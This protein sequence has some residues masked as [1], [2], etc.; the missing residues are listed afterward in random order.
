MVLCAITEHILPRKPATTC[1]H[2]YRPLTFTIPASLKISQC[3]HVIISLEPIMHTNLVFSHVHRSLALCFNKSS[4][5]LLIVLLS[6]LFFQYSLII[7]Q[8]PMVLHSNVTPPNLQV[9]VPL[10][11]VSSQIC[12]NLVPSG[13]VYHTLKSAYSFMVLLQHWCGV[14]ARLYP[15]SEKRKMCVNSYFARI[16]INFFIFILSK[17]LI[18]MNAISLKLDTN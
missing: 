16:R 7:L 6:H 15:I 1:Y 3:N 8:L 13:I 5:D 11:A 10:N 12:L 4:F 2:N 14:T 9:F 18:E 17:L